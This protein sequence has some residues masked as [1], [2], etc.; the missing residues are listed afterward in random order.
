[1]YWDLKNETY[2]K[3]KHNSQDE[4]EGTSHDASH[5]LGL[6]SSQTGIRGQRAL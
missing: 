5:A 3:G 4:E 6:S 2:N 1:M